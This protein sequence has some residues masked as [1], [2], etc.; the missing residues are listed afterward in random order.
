MAMV[1]YLAYIS[2]YCP[3]D[4]SSLRLGLRVG[5]HMALAYFHSDDPSELSHMA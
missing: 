1:E 3:T 5:G 2:S 4:R